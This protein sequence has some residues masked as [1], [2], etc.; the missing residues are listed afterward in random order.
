MSRARAAAARAGGG[1]ESLS[2]LDPRC[3]RPHPLHDPARNYPETNCW[4][5]VIIELL[6]AC[7]YEPLAAFAHLVR[8]DFE[9]DQWTFFKPPADDLEALFGVDVHEMQPYRPLPAQI[10]EQLAFGRSMIVE[11]DSWYLPDLAAT[12][13]RGEHVKTAIAADAIDVEQQILRY[14]HG[15]GLY[16][17]RGEDYRGAFRLDGRAAD[18]LP[19][20]AELVRFDAG[21]RLE[22]EELRRESERTLRRHLGRRPAGSPF[23][24]FA[25]QLERALPALLAGDLDGYHAYAFATARMLGSACEVLSSYCQWLLG[26]SG[27]EAA[28]A[29]IEVVEASKALSFR[30]ARRRRFEP[31][32]LLEAMAGSWER[33]LHSIEE[34]LG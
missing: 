23:E 33:A 15:P 21:P 18:A 1:L 12:S 3:Y 28:A 29:L 16:E 8:I 7:G 26:A 34:A 5:D 32:A 25:A 20:Y 13:Y 11:V 19:P 17:L 14:F 4:S 9:G 31:R 6:H 22:G 27:A 30:L 24:R 2:G 10:A